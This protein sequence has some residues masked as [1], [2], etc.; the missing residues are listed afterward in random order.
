[1]K[2]KTSFAI[3]QFFNNLGY[4]LFALTLQG[5][6]L[7]SKEMSIANYGIISALN[8]FPIVFLGYFAGKIADSLNRKKTLIIIDIVRGIIIISFPFIDNLVILAILVVINSSLFS[9]YRG[10][11]SGITKEIFINS[12]ER[13]NINSIFNIMRNSSMLISPFLIRFL[14]ESWT[15]IFVLSGLSFILSSFFIRITPYINDIRKKPDSDFKNTSGINS[16]KYIFENKTLKILFLLTLAYAL[17]S[18]T[19]NSL[20][21]LFIRDH[22]NLPESYISN[23][24][25]SIGFGSIISAFVIRRIS[26]KF[27]LIFGVFMSILSFST[28]MVVLSVTSNILVISLCAFLIGAIFSNF[29]ILLTTSLQ[30][31]VNLSYMGKI[32]NIFNSIQVG[33]EF[34]VSFSLGLILNLF[35]ISQVYFFSSMISLLMA[36]I[37]FI[38]G[39]KSIKSNNSKEE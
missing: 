2:K 5:Y 17:I 12:E 16:V 14:N 31:I 34:I 23:F 28:V 9:I 39:F 13:L 19:Y 38:F 35:K 29:S 1:M 3:S 36:I 30:N 37:I 33:F 11:F 8:I 18:G 4:Y 10:S 22:L 27:D 25:I 15:I 7:Y 32:S 21:F 26:I 24:Q 20:W 6:F